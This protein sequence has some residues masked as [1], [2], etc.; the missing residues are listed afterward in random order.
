MSATC[1]KGHASSTD[2]YCDQCGAA[3][4]AAASPAPTA[5]SPS[6]ECANCGRA[7]DAD[8]LFCEVCGLDFT[9]GK[10]PEAPA[11][12]KRAA[13]APA[14]PTSTSPA[15]TPAPAGW[16]VVVA[17]DRE[18]FDSN[19]AESPTT[20]LTF[21]EGRL[22]AD[23]PLRA[24]EVLVGRRREGSDVYPE[25]DL[26]GPLDDPGVSRR[27]ATLRSTGDAWDLVDLDSTNG[28]RVNGKPVPPGQP[29][30]L[31]DGDRIHVGAWTCL[32]LRRP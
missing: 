27:H 4:D 12:P 19:Q 11:A 3:I 26:S 20:A 25:V 28:T 1:S 17:T 14:T 5:A 30:A 2:D 9:T 23:V 6:L 10:L 16:V 7:H 32:T 31:A 24:A 15:T 29:T 18:F 8:E 22:D 13:A 21:P